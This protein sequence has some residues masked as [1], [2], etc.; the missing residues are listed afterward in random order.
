MGETWS[1]VLA[2]LRGTRSSSPRRPIER[3]HS[4]ALKLLLQSRENRCRESCLFLN[5]PAEFVPVQ[6]LEFRI[7]TRRPGVDR[8]DHGVSVGR[9]FVNID[10]GHSNTTWDGADLRISV[11]TRGDVLTLSVSVHGS[12]PVNAAAASEKKVCATF[13][14]RAIV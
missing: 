1:G 9:N 8:A 5:E 11:F 3:V 10:N 2:W 12:K 7:R 13:L 6:C 14:P 4:S